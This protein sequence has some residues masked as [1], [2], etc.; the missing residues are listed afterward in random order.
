MNSIRKGLRAFGAAAAG[1]QDTADSNH[2][3][4]SVAGSYASGYGHGHHS[5]Y[6]CCCCD[7]KE[8]DDGGLLDDQEFLAL[9]GLG[10]AAVLFLN[11]AITMAAATRRRR[12]RSYPNEAFENDPAWPQMMDPFWETIQAGRR[13]FHFYSKAEWP[14][15]VRLLEVFSQP[16]IDTSEILFGGY[17]NQAYKPWLLP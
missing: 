13:F 11:M 12:K 5:G 15:G 14:Y 2:V 8:D 17:Q 9:L 10:A 1:R 4:S 7:K 3:T 6:G 16:I